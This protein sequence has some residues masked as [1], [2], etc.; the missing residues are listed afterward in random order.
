MLETGI[1]NGG[2]A[3][4]A[5]IAL[6]AGVLSFLSP[7]VLPIVP[8]YLAYMGGISMRDMAAE[9]A[10]HRAARRRTVAAAACFVLGLSTVFLLLGFAASTFGRFIAGWMDWFNL[11]AGIVIMVF[12][13]HFLGVIRLG[14]LNRDMRMDA[15]DRGG[16]AFGAYLLGLA[17]AFG[18]W[19]FFL[20]LLPFWGF[21][22]G[23]NVGTDATTALFGDGTF[24][25]LLSWA[26][27]LVF[28]VGFALFSYLYYYGAI[29]LL[30][31]AVGYVI[32]T[33]AWGLI[34][35]EY[36]LIA[37]VIGLA[38][39]AVVAIVIIALNV[40]RLLVIVMT[41]LG[42]AAAV[43]AGWFILVGDIPTDSIHWTMVGALIRDSWF[44]LIVW[45]VIAAAG[46]LVQ[47]V[48][49]AIG[50]DTYE[51]DRESYRYS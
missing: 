29:A 9:D 28:A 31:G 15:G 43:L 1:T 30:G 16:S 45:G 47:L 40:P 41:G 5:L 7:C 22:V 10:D 20:L 38:V 8:P 2:F 42:G 36:G 21:L 44:Y 14:F 51:L 18:G 4:A 33:S 26:I 24:A 48:T 32:G 37:F 13:A 3:L 23:F 11:I 17:F 39:G 50:P 12:G 6:L 34:G 49:P 27:G 25:T 19:R 46:M 35:N